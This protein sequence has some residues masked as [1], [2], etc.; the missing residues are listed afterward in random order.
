MSPKTNDSL[1]QYH[2]LAEGSSHPYK[3]VSM[4]KH[5][6]NDRKN[7]CD[8]KCKTPGPEQNLKFIF[9]SP[10]FFVFCYLP[11]QSK[12]HCLAS[13]TFPISCACENLK[14]TYFIF[15]S[16]EFEY[17]RY[18][19][20]IKSYNICPSVTGLFPWH[21]V[22]KI[23]PSCHIFQNFLFLKAEQYFIVCVFHVFFTCSSVG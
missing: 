10:L 3:L 18:L 6:L 4:E 21:N 23:H 9:P 5:W 20:Q 12:Y 17:F 11:V 19:I 7:K 2:G 13:F 15:C 22:L 14:N 16:Y 8:G 1:V